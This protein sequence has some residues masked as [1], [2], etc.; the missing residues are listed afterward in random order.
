ME[1]GQESAVNLRKKLSC[2]FTD[3]IGIM[4]IPPGDCQFG[5]PQALLHIQR[6]CPCLQKHGCMR[7]SQGVKIKQRHIQFSMGNMIGVLEGM[8]LDEGSVFPGI[9]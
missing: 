6:V 8:G 4:R 9:D 7:M 5:M 3:E 2:L 1:Y